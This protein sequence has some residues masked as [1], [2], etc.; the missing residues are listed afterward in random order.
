MIARDSGAA[1]A[2]SVDTPSG[3]VVDASGN[4]FLADTRNHRV[5]RVAHDTG[6][7]TTVAGGGTA[8]PGGPAT[9]A[10]IRLPRGLSVDSSG[11][12]Y[13]ADT[14]ANQI[15][16]VAVD[17]TLSVAAGAGTQGLSGDGGAASAALL[18]S[19]RGAA[20]SA[21]G[22]LAIADTGNQRLREAVSGGTVQTLGGVGPATP[23][24]L[25]LTAPSVVQYGTG[26][27]AATLA[28]GAAATGS[29]AFLEVLAGTPSTLGTQP[30]VAGVATFSTAALPAGAHSILATYA[31]DASRPS[32][33][34]AVFLITVTPAPVTATAAPAS[35]LYGQ[36]IPAIT[37]TVSGVLARDAALVSVSFATAAH[38]LSPAG[39][40]PVIASLSGQAAQNYQLSSDSP[41]T[42]V[43]GHAPTVTSISASATTVTQGSTTTLSGRAASTTAGVPTGR[44]AFLDAGAPMGSATID[45]TGNASLTTTLGPGDHTLSAAY[46]GDANFLSSASALISEVV[47]PAPANAPDFTLAASGAS[48]QTITAGAQATFAFA[49]T[50]QNGPLNSPIQ[51]SAGGLPPGASST[52]NPAY[53]PPGGAVPTFTLTIQTVKATADLRRG[54]RPDS[55]WPIR[56]LGAMLFAPWTLRRR[57]NRVAPFALGLCLL[58]GAGCGDRIAQLPPAT[59]P[60]AT[61]YSILVTGTSTLPG[62]AVLQHT[63]PIT[64]TVQ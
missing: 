13:V 57:R 64:V 51:L 22:L 47:A 19:P 28:F 48:S 54:S 12:L 3:L 34:S 42:F 10:A 16:E 63:V 1:V 11:N 30:L 35:A 50:M 55:G 61:S 29:V 5:R 52:F 45:A 7:I 2:A 18:D 41:G 43:I 53:L 39:S 25:T 40:Y 4:L 46:P 9:G 8:L 60:V 31:G 26:N 36:P 21:A 33:Q 27:I 58:G 32:V 6:I 14:N 59:G 20:I 38:T 44:L 49:V 37:G 23:G 24:S 56:L 62:G 15:L 17:G